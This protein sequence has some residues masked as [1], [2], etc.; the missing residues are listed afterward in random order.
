MAATE[1]RLTKEQVDQ[2]HDQGFLAIDAV[3]TGDDLTRIQQAIDAL[4]D[5]FH[6]L[7]KNVALDIA[8][9]G[10]AA[11]SAPRIPEIN[12]AIRLAPELSSSATFQN[13]RAIAQQLLDRAPR[14][15]GDHAIY[16]PPRNKKETPWHQDQAYL[17]HPFAGRT[18]SFWVPLQTVTADMGCMRFIPGSHKRGVLPHHK[19]QHNPQAHALTTDDVD[20]SAVVTCPL[21]AG[22]ATVHCPLTLHA[23]GPND[24]DVTR[25]A[26]IFAFTANRP[27]GF[28]R[29]ATVAVSVARRVRSMVAS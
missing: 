17:G 1:P 16:K 8:Q 6:T 14:F 19:W 25:R 15:A 22:G 24:A 4:F 20:L 27:Y 2:Y 23:T 5:R 3:T 13:C 10:K 18:V 21:P 29:A 26:W 11:M 7:P 28:V 12:N 9:D